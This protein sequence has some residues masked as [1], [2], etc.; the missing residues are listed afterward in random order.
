M[1]REAVVA[2]ANPDGSTHLT[3]LG[4]RVSGEELLL[5]PFVPSR[6]LAN[7]RE[8]GFGALNFTDDVRVIAGCLTGRRD[9]PTTACRDVR[10]ARLESALAHTEFDVARVDEDEQRPRFFCRRIRTENHR[11][12]LGY[13]RAQAAVIEAAI[14]VSR[15]DFLEPAVVRSELD[16]LLPAVEKTAGEHER[17][18]WSWLEA[19][20]HDHPRHRRPESHA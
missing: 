13:N 5:A 11:P 9:W 15:L 8:R 2:T 12:F 20:V 10:C 19:A 4:Y 17:L 1:I 18:A 6:T 3:P 14:L 7:L 16:R